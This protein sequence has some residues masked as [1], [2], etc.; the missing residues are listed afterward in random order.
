MVSSR[1]SSTAGEVVSIV[2]DSL[3]KQD[4]RDV[5]PDRI[6]SIESRLADGYQR[7]EAAKGA[8]ADT[9]VWEDYWISLLHSYED[10]CDG[11]PRAA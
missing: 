5:P 4:G 9:R 7:I 11:L 6:A 10:L 3:D 8:G 2:P 1:G